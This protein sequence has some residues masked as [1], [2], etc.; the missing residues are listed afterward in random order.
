[1]TLVRPKKPLLLGGL[2]T[3]L[4]IL[5]AA[6]AVLL[7]AGVRPGGATHVP[8]APAH[9]VN[10]YSAKFLCGLI[11]QEA[12]P[13]K[14]LAPG[15]YNTAINIHNPNDFQ[16]TIQ[17]KA[18]ISVPERNGFPFGQPGARVTELLN[19]DASMEIDCTDV[20]L[21]LNGGPG[22]GGAVPPCGPT[23][24]PP[25]LWSDFCKGYV[26][27]EAARIVIGPV[28]SSGVPAQLDVTDILTVKE[29][30]G[31]WKDY[32]FNLYCNLPAVQ[33]PQFAYPN[34]PLLANLRYSTTAP[35]LVQ[36]PM[37]MP[38]RPQIPA[39]YKTPGLA[40]QP[41]D[42]DAEIRN[43]L[44]AYCNGA[45]GVNCANFGVPQ[46]AV[47]FLEADYATDS[48]DVSLDFEFVS[49]KV[50]RYN[51]WPKGSAACP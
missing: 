33:C 25:V 34:N 40:C 23:S 49:P 3:A 29:E 42:A 44:R 18:V 24:P 50:V 35:T 17:K 31:I 39:C 47:E 22:G 36:Y 4:L 46:V 37:N 48:R 21:L 38:H 27:I 43:S 11:T 14:P 15:T 6:V 2:G 45:G 26:V 19:P 28:V 20:L 13:F 51:C 32:S 41:Y 9:A 5:G 30:D 7:L 1:M 16:V 10:Q 12:D 8:N